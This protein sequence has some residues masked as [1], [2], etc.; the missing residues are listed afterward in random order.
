MSNSKLQLVYNA[1][2]KSN[3]KKWFKKVNELCTKVTGLSVTDFEDYAWHSNFEDELSPGTA[4]YYFFEENGYMRRYPEIFEAY[5][6][7]SE[8]A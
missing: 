8:I 2:G 4:L 1:D 5:H 3:F 6:E 7:E